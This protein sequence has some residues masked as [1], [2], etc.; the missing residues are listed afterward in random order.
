MRKDSKNCLLIVLCLPFSRKQ[1]KYLDFMSKYLYLL[2][3]AIAVFLP[4]TYAQASPP[5]AKV[6]TDY[7]QEAFVIEEDSTRIIFENDGTSVRESAARVRIQSD[8]GVQR[9]GLLTF[10]YQ[11][12]TESMDIDYVRARKPDGTIVLTPA[13]NVQDMPAEVTR[14][15]PFYSDLREKHVAVKGLGA[16]DVL[17]YQIHWHTTK[18]LAP[19]QF[20]F[21]Y[22][23][24]H[25]SIEV[26]EQLQIGVPRE[27]AVQFKSSDIKPVI[28]EEGAHRVYTWTTSNLEHKSEEEKFEQVQDRVRGRLPGPNVLLSSFKSWEEVGRWYGSLQREKIKPSAEIRAKAAEITKNAT[29]EDAKLRAIYSY[30]SNRFRYIGIAF[31]IGRY[32]PHSADEVLSNQYGDCKD[33]HTLLASLLDAAGIKA[34][35]A[36]INVSHSLDPDVPSPGQFDHVISVVPQGNEFIWLDTT[37]EVAPFAYLVTVLQNKPALVIPDDKPPLLTTSPASSSYKLSQRFEIDAKLD[38]K[39]TLEGKIER[40]IRGD[41]SE[42]VM[43]AAFRSVPLPQWKDLIQ[44]ISYASGFAGTVSEAT[45]SSPEA[46]SEPFRFSYH[47][48]RKDFP[49]W[50]NRR[51]SPPLPPIILPSLKDDQSKPTQPIWLGPAGEIRFHSQVEL[52]KGYAPELPATV[53]IKRDFAEYHTSYGIKNSRLVTERVL[54]LKLSEVPVSEY[55]DYKSFRKAV[56][57]DHD[58]Y[59]ELSSGNSTAGS[60]Q[61]AIW[62]LPDSDNPEALRAYNEARNQVRNQGNWPA[63]IV[64]LKHAVDADPKYIRAWLWLGEIYKFRGQFALALDAY[65]KAINI[66]PQLPIGY[67]ALAFTLLSMRNYEQSIPVWQELIKLAPADTDGPANLG[68]VLIRFKRY[69]EATAALESAVKLNPERSALQ[70]RLGSAYLRAGNEDKGMAAFRKV[71][72]INPGSETLNDVAYELAEAN[73]KLPEA[74][75]YVQRAVR[76]EEEASQTVQLSQLQLDDVK[77]T[78][79]IAAYWDTLG[80]VHFRLGNLDQAEKYLNAAWT[81]SQIAVVGDHLGQVYERQGKRQ[82]AMHTYALAV[83]ANDGMDETRGRLTRLIGSRLRADGAVNQARGELSR[84]RTTRVTKIVSGSASAEFFVLLGPG[85]KVE[86]VKFISGSDKLKSAG[87]V[88]SSILFRL[89]FPDDA[90]TRLVRRGLLGCFAVTGCNFVL[91]T[92]DSVRSLD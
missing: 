70:L 7:S 80:W 23:F 6:K 1:D 55:E 71:L 66:D 50:E 87:K 39:G 76:Q 89:P 18:P 73:K 26:Q 27:R 46:T 91:Y 61:N 74:L 77:R 42:L 56:N 44:Q 49:D 84:M 59:I 92:L 81:L 60:Y 67:K 36:L 34:Y 43:R 48:S 82:A 9:F 41:D 85:S 64:S 72:E 21:A 28:S 38:E 2:F 15:A 54:T 52:P 10:S 37:P 13:D 24:S 40:S 65:H 86:D 12:S 19:G 62:N 79:T 5:P 3:F 53:D 29:D 57:D 51:I 8:A 78:G 58:R 68:M 20:W 22:N 83:A 25:D 63:A 88:L 32:Q 31:G 69:D 75:Q 16:G 35:P 90:P 30:V 4:R 14:T 33:K 47:Y 11:N 45:A 17:E